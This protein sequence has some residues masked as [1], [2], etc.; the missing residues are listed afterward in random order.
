MLSAQALLAC[1]LAFAGCSRTSEQGAQAAQSQPGSVA[2][3]ATPADKGAQAASVPLALPTIPAGTVISVRLLS[4][5]SSSSAHA[6]EEYDAE[7]AAPLTV[8]GQTLFAQ[9]SPARIRV[10]SV[11]ASGRLQN[12]GRLR[13]ALDS[14]K[15]QSGN[16]VPVETTPLSAKGQSHEKRNATLIGGGA[17][18]G[19][20][21]GALAGGGKG[22]AIGAL[23]GA[24]AG[25]A[26]AYATGK[27]D[28]A[29]YAERVLVFR[30]TGGLSMNR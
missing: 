24:G 27:K 20:A 10:V 7:L 5:I 15:D 30:A 11:Q 16:W 9:S 19:A 2:N 13:I 23:S 17:A 1:V 8:E 6:G 26:G 28:V 4:T 12:P 25:S 22:A 14:I 29:Y 18:F 21:I 3:P